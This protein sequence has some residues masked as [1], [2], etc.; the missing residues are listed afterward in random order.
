MTGYTG[1]YDCK[2]DV[3]G[4]LK[5]PAGILRQLPEGHQGKFVINKG[6]D[7][8]LDLYTLSAWGKVTEKLEK[9]NKFNSKHRDF[10][11]AFYRNAVHVELDGSDRMLIS[12]RTS[13]LIGLKDEAV[14]IGYGSNLEIWAKEE[15]ETKINVEIDNFSDMADDI[16]GNINLNE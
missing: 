16:L 5:L 7:N 8:N 14:I 12:K 13:E 3:K 10:L 6:L 1:Q 11:R 15:Y 2:I 9:L 4:R